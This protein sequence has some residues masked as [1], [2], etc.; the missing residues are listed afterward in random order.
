MAV[1][2]LWSIN[3]DGLSR[4]LQYAANPKKTNNKLYISG[5]NCEPETAY[6]EFTAVKR[7]YAKADGIEAYHGYLSFK[8]QNITPELTMKIGTEF[9][10]EVWGKRFQVLVTV[11]TDTEHPHCH[12][13]I[14]SVS[15]VD[16]KKLWGE[17]KAWFK[18][19]QTADRLCEKYGLYYNPK[20]VRG[21]SSSYH[22]NR[23]KK[24]EPTRYLLA[25]EAMEKALLQ[26]TNT[27]DLRYT[28]AKLGYELTMNDRR[29]YWTITPKGS[30]KPIRLVKLS[31]DY[32]PE[33]IRHRLVNNRYDRPP[34]IDYRHYRPK[35]Y[36]LPTCGDRILQRTSVIYRIYLYYAFRLGVIHSYRRP[37]PAKLHWIFK[38]ELAY[39]D[40]LSEEVRL[41]GREKISTDVE[42]LA[43][44]HKLEDRIQTFTDE[45]SDLRKH[46]RRKISADELKETKDKITHIT[47][48]LRKLRHKL[49]LCEHIAERS[50]VMEQGLETVLNDEQKTRA[51]NKSRG[52]ER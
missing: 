16:G 48:N 49:K 1:S 26:C 47:I 3:E 2:K 27:A 14:N 32:T 50:K 52:Y 28:L 38:D 4:V 33:G 43:Y 22:Y 17:E 19:K 39:L 41:M 12:F 23:E 7:S 18:F 5:I 42:L 45:R 6:E 24:G 31:A 40:R 36:K 30:K 9:A 37:D 44:K 10:Q 34:R 29:K 11:H 15:F 25:R 8:E 51:K 21:K 46:S 20:L 35:Q 13:V